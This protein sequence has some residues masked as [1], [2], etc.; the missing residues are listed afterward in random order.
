MSPISF[1][2]SP[3]LTRFPS[4]NCPLLLDP[5]HFTRPSSRSAQVCRVPAARLTAKRSDPKFTAGRD[6]WTKNEYSPHELSPIDVPR[7]TVSP[8]PS[9]PSVFAPQ[10]FTRPS[11]RIA[12]VWELPATIL[13]IQSLLLEDNG[14]ASQ[15]GPTI[16]E[17][18]MRNRPARQPAWGL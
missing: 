2:S 16:L 3:R 17:S 8:T 5:Q 4:P 18:A 11:Y 13:D 14:A 10:H 6:K 15:V 7:F 1:G 9:C 12:Q